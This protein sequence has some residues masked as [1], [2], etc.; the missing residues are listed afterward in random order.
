MADMMHYP[1]GFTEQM[2]GNLLQPI[3]AVHDKSVPCQYKA[4]C[5]ETRILP[6]ITGFY[7][8]CR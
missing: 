1:A 7:G 2:G 6:V 4:T 5:H 8:F 3:N